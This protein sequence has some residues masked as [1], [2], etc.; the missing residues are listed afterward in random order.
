MTYCACRLVRLVLCAVHGGFSKR[1]HRSKKWDLEP[2]IRASHCTLHSWYVK[3]NTIFVFLNLLDG[4]I[5][6]PGQRVAS[7]YLVSE[8][9]TQL[10]SVRDWNSIQLVVEICLIPPP[11]FFLIPLT[12]LTCST[13]HNE[14]NVS[15]LY[16]HFYIAKTVSLQKKNWTATV[17]HKQICQQ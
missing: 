12:S 15:S 2:P 11:H 13:S 1:W 6:S 8:M 3:V 4:T 9:E 10:N 14:P 16:L 7:D 5:S 17:I